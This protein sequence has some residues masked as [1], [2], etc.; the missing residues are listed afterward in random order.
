MK[1]ERRTIYFWKWKTPSFFSNKRWPKFCSSQPTKLIFGMQHWF[2]YMKYGRQ[3][4]FFENGRQTYFVLNGRRPHFFLN[5]RRPEFFWKLKTTSIFGKW[6][7]TSTFW[8]WKATSTFW[9]MEDG[10]IFF[11]EIGR[12]PHF[13]ISNKT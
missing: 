2:N 8:K 12:L 9:K 11:L 10:I 3:P 4:N 6:K 1:Y 13:Y 5:G 7:T